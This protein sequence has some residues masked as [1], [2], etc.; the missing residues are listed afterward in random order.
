MNVW[1]ITKDKNFGDLLT[2]H[3]LNFFNI[4][5][6]YINSAKLADCLCVG[7]IAHWSSPNK[8]MLGS[9]II[10]ADSKISPD[11][12]WKFVRGPQTRKRIINAGGRCPEIYGDPGLLLSLLCKESQK[13]F[14][15]GIVPH[16]VDY[17]YV[18]NKYPQFKIINVIDDNPINVAKEISKCRYIISSS[19]HGIIAAHSYNIP[20]AWVKFSNNVYGDDI[21]FIDYFE[22]V[23][24]DNDMLSTF[25]SPKFTKGI[26]NLDP[27][28][29]I[30]KSL[31]AV[32]GIT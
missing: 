30:F 25:D 12:N 31:G 24:I 15:V 2:P 9:G 18:K 32:N 19:L 29:N 16:F 20:A 17:Q 7:S 1:W 5:Y 28:I 4:Q 22:S 13:E 3:I 27:I 14:D 21:K 26:F 23:N 6:N 11:A 10:T 8:I